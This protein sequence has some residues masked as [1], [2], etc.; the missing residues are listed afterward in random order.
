MEAVTAAGGRGAVTGAGQG[1]GEDREHQGGG[2]AGHL[3]GPG[4][5]DQTE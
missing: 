1:E 3:P 2:R 5:R 4:G